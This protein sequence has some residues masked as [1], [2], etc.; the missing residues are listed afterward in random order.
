MSLPPLSAWAG[1]ISFT[2][3]TNHSLERS[4]TDLRALYTAY[5]DGRIVETGIPWY[6]A[7]FGR[8][9]LITGWQTLCLNPDIARDTLRFLSRYQGRELDE[10]REVEP[11][12]ILHEMR[13]GEMANCG[14]ILHTPYYGSIDATPLFI[15]LLGDYYQWTGDDALLAEMRRPLG[16]ALSWCRDYGDRDG[17][18][19]LE[20]IGRAKGGLT[21]QGWKDSWG[22]VVH[23]DGKLAAP[24]IALVEVQAYWYRALEQGARL[25]AALGE[26]QEARRLLGQARDLKRR[27]IRD[28]WMADKE[29]LGFAL[30]GQKKLLSTVVSN[31]GHCLFTGILEPEAAGKVVRRLFQPDMYSGWGIRTLSKWEK[32]YNPMSYHNGSVWPHDNA[33]IAAGLRRY[34]YL[35]Q[36]ERLF[37]GLFEAALH[38]P[39]YRLPELFCGFTRRPTGAPVRYPIACD[40]QAWALGTPFMLLRAVLGLSGSTSGLRVS[41]PRLPSW[42]RELTV[43]NL[44]IRGGVIDLRFTRHRERTHCYLLR[45]EG[46]VRVT[47]EV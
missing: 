29:C 26:E 19:Y 18:G 25:A 14:E 33:V 11:G 22:A 4:V 3:T 5:P 46:D 21:N 41:Q 30:D 40:P 13:R 36:L 44:R 1:R 9:A 8:D 6:A 2:P 17:D 39:Y 28:F 24:P 12:K 42:L 10:R 38:F 47:I 37:T 31:M 32:P 20:Y 34:G 23:P 27:F 45:K 15:I 16:A 7:P 35:D 43:T